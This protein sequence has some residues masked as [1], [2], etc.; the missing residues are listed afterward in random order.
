MSEETA[1]QV[2]K[3]ILKEE[4]AKAEK[5]DPLEIA[6]TMFGIYFPRFCSKIDKLSSRALRRV[7][8]AIVETPLNQVPYNPK[9]KDEKEAFAIAKGLMDAK[10]VMI[11][12]T[13]SQN[14][15]K[16]LKEAAEASANTNEPLEK[17]EETNNG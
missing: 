16:I 4:A 7:I 2:E 1:V 3:E 9:D 8:K 15:E 10:M 11:F 13:Y 17:K 14:S 12:D 5:A 6:A